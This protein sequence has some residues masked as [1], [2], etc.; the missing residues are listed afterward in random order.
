VNLNRDLPESIE[1]D[2]ELEEILTRPSQELIDY[3][4]TV[5]SPLVIVGAGGKMGPTLAA[6]AKRAAA[7][8]GCSLEVIAISRFGDTQARSWLEQ[9]GVTTL[10]C[11][12]LK[13]GALQSLPDSEN[14][15]YLV[16]LKFGT[17][18]TPASTWAVNCLAPSRIAERYPKARLVA[19]STGNVYPL[20]A[21]SKGGLPETARLTP[22]GEYSNS[23][24][25][26][27]RIF[28]FYSLSDGLRLA[29]LRLSYA[30]E[31]RYGV[32]VD[33]AQQIQTGAPVDLANGY[34]NCIWQGD[35]NDMIL[36]ALALADS[37]PSVWNLCRPEKFSVR[38]VAEQLGELLGRKPVFGGTESPTALLSNS[39]RIC[40]RLGKPSTSLETLLR[41]TA[42]WI[43]RGGRILGKPTHF[44]VRDGNY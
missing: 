41:W 8:A 6:R 30:V 18:K 15:V 29:L 11:D 37:P 25:G 13:P 4:P 23:A 40:A 39:Q 32:L 19:L 24:V 44:E 35:A 42:A 14:V 10:S 12:L 2:A 1:T 16:G 27:E 26:R 17:G 43:K 5:S 22:L 38:T 21:V 36:R 33:L 34:F 3:I 7:L 9:Q 31:L 20:A 28:E